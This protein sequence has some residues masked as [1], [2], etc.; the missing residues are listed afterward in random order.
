VVSRL[1]LWIN[2]E[3]REAAFGRRAQ[4][5][6]A[7]EQVVKVQRRDPVLVTT[8]GPDLVQMQCFPVPANGTM[9]VR[10]G[11]TAPLQLGGARRGDVQLPHLVDR[12]FAV[13]G[14]NVHVVWVE[15]RAPLHA[16]TE[17]LHAASGPSPAQG[18]PKSGVRG[19]LSDAQLASRVTLS[20]K[21]PG[22][23]DRVWFED[24]FDASVGVIVQH[25]EAYTEP[26]PPSVHRAHAA[27][28]FGSRRGRNPPPARVPGRAGR[29]AAAPPR[30]GSGRR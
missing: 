14:G 6:Q 10:V 26:A 8:V 18:R 11:V 28:N 1:T 30:V 12:N 15:S 3:E 9:K 20:A 7:Y 19:V 27:G 21:P 5:R 4:V 24:P 16:A 23:V 25:V 29:R 22:G 17:G 13:A 2:G